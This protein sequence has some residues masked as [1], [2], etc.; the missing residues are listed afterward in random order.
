MD[1]R[2]SASQPH[3][4]QDSL[5][6]LQ[7]HLSAQIKENVDVQGDVLKAM[8]KYRVAMEQLIIAS[9]DICHA[10]GKL[11]INGMKTFQ[12][13]ASDASEEDGRGKPLAAAVEQMIKFY[14]VVSS[15]TRMLTVTIANDFE[16]T[17]ALSLD[18]HRQ[19]ASV[20]R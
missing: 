11:S 4:R 13:A 18:K 9:N 8:T 2:P 5:D 14:T 19:L 1:R 20:S 6:A 16:P 15:Q 17:L 7:K 10:L 12:T 3:L